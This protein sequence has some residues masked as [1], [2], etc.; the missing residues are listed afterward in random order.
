MFDEWKENSGTVEPKRAGKLVT[1]D[2]Y[3]YAL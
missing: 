3:S 1:Y 2:F